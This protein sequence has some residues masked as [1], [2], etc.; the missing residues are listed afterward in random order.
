MT[1]LKFQTA[2][3][4]VISKYAEM[5]GGFGD[6]SFFNFEQDSET[7]FFLLPPWKQNRDIVLLAREIYESFLPEKKKWV[8]LRSW[9]YIN[10][11][12]AASDPIEYHLNQI[13]EMPGTDFAELK[14]HKPKARFYANVL[15]SGVKKLS[16]GGE[17]VPFAKFKEPQIINMPTTVWNEICSLMSKPGFEVPYDPANAILFVVSRTGR[18]LNTEYRV[19][20]AGTRGATGDVTPNRFNLVNHIEVG[21]L[22]L[23]IDN[24]TDLDKR[25]PIPDTSGPEFIQRREEAKRVLNA[26]F[27]GINV[28]Q[29]PGA[30]LAPMGSSVIGGP[31][32]GAQLPPAPQAPMAPPPAPVAPPPPV[33]PPAPSQVPVVPVAP[34]APAP[35]RPDLRLL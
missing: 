24:L 28:N 27:N 18:G 16:Q 19:E 13:A 15:V 10:P 14:R 17:F 25:W 12:L 30:S 34:V 3:N 29:V 20:F 26:K 4:G 21:E 9:G 22:Q 6:V 7:S 35:P 33:A 23:L 1:G 2:D 11:E 32:Q 31:P 8:S 5:S